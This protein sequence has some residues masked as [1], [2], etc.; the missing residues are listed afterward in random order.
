[1][2]TV[3]AVPES[4]LTD[5]EPCVGPCVDIQATCEPGEGSVAVLPAAVAKSTYPP[6]APV[7]AWRVQPVE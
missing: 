4:S 2:L 1:M 6:L 5:A 3:A 7:S